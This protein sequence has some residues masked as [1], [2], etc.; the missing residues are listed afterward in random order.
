[1]IKKQV[2]LK[3]IRLPENDLQL[4]DAMEY[5]QQV[6]T[7]LSDLGIPV[8]NV[9]LRFFHDTYNGSYDVD[10]DMFFVEV[11]YET[12]KTEED[13]K[14]EIEFLEIKK[15]EREANDRIQFEKM[16]KHYGWS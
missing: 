3:T 2:K 13:R 9:R 8:T 1:M 12:E 15:A 7:E 10:Q 6:Y 11:W 4:D 14:K 5:L 16:K